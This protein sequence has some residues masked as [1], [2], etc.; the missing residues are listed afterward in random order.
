MEELFGP[1][2]GDQFNDSGDFK[3]GPTQ[4]LNEPEPGKR[5]PGRSRAGEHV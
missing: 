5:D 1:G 3:L 2:F 4:P